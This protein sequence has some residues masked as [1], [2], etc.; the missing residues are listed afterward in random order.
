MKHTLEELISSTEDI[1]VC[2]IFFDIERHIPVSY[3]EEIVL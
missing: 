1:Q 3:I 2:E